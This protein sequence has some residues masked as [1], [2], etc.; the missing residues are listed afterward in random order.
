MPH[1]Y[2]EDQLVEQAAIVLFAE[3]M[4]SRYP[5]HR[6]FSHWREGGRQAGFGV[7]SL[8]LAVPHLRRTLEKLNPSLP[9]F[10]EVPEA[11]TNRFHLTKLIAAL[12]GL[13]K[14]IEPKERK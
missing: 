8:T 6:P 7:R 10:R 13:K 14:T 5:H 3:Q 4:A 12:V 2:T 11:N 9:L 1:A